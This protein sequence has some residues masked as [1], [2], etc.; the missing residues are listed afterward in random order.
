MASALKLDRLPAFRVP[1]IRLAA[2]EELPLTVADLDAAQCRNWT[3]KKLDF[4]GEGGG[5]DT[6]VFGL[7]KA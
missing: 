2:L 7:D 3:T 4:S 6:L 1:T 5:R